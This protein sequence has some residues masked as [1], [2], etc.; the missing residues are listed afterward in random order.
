MKRIAIFLVIMCAAATAYAL[1]E[2]NPTVFTSVSS[3][4]ADVSYTVTSPTVIEFRPA[5]DGVTYYKGSGT[6]F[7]APKDTNVRLVVDSSI[8][9]D[10]AS[11]AHPGTT[12]YIKAG[13][14]PVQP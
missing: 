11:S 12:I 2:F 9:F 13:N 10:V 6:K 14:N 7:P 4:K 5:A 1:S 8:T 3:T